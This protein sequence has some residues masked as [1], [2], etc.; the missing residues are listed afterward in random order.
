MAIKLKG[1]D[2]SY[3]QKTVN[4]SKVKS[5]GNTFV[6]LKLGNAK[7]TGLT[8]DAMFEKHYAGCKAAGLKVGVYI[9]AYC[10]S[11]TTAKKCASQTLSY[12]SKFD[13]DYPVAFDIEFEQI[14]ISS[15]SLATKNTNITIAFLDTIKAGGYY[16]M[17]YTSPSM[18]YSYL[19]ADKLTKYETWVAQYNKSCTYKYNYGMWQYDVAGHPTWDI[20]GIGSVP[21]VNGQ[22][23]CNYAYKDYA[24]I[25]S[26]GG[27]NKKKK[28]SPTVN[29]TPDNSTGKTT[30][31]FTVGDVVTI[32][33]G[34]TAY[35]G[36][37]LSDS[38]YGV[39]YKVLEVGV[40]QT[41]R[42]VVGPKAGVYIAAVSEKNLT[43]VLATDKP[44]TVTFKV[45]DLVTVNKGA[46]TVAGGSLASFVYTTTYK[47]LK[48]NGTQITIGPKANAV[49]AVIY[50]KDLTKK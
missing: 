2:L 8:I 40:K 26:E 45:G 36:S 11:T 24:K 5:A 30:G 12:L 48:V 9:Y 33:K 27:Y 38:V 44:T 29:P 1:I 50:A 23:D 37:K 14:Y 15:T 43:K 20:H 47:V 39:K 35:D 49:T 10:T 42:I 31:T 41:D 13:I 22:C 17:L 7:D 3:C 19:K 28:T 4:Y 18:M 32:N 25:I 16:P 21:G 34:A 46:K 6:M